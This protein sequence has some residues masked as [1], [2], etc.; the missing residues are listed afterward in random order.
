[1]LEFEDSRGTLMLFRADRSVQKQSPF[2]RVSQGY[3]GNRRDRVRFTLS[4][5]SLEDRVVMTT[6]P[7]TI[8]L[9]E[10]LPSASI[11]TNVTFTATV[12]STNG[13]P[14]GSVLFEDGSSVLGSGTLSG[15]VAAFSTNSLPIGVHQIQAFYGGTSTYLASATASASA[16]S[17]INTVAGNGTGCYSGDG[18]PATSAELQNPAYAAFDASG[19]MFISDSGN[20]VIRK[21]TPS[22]IISTYAGNGTSGYSGDGGAATSA[23]LHTP[24]GLAVDA[25]GDL[26]IADSQNN[27]IREVNT[28]GMIS[29][30][31]GNG[32]YGYTGDGGPATNAEMRYPQD[33]K[34]NTSGDVF[35]VD[36][37]NN[38]I[39]EVSTTGIISTVAGNGSAGYSGDGGP[40]TSAQLA[41]PQ[42][43]AFDPSGDMFIADYGNNV[44]R[45]VS[46]SGVISTFAGNGTYAYSGDGGPATSAAIASPEGIAFD[47]HG[48]LFIADY[49]NSVIR[50]VTPNGIISTFAGN[51]TYT[52]TGD[53]GPAGLAGID[54]PY[55]VA[56]SPSGNIAITDNGNEV[57][58]EVSA[59]SSVPF[60]FTVTAAPARVSLVVNST[61]QGTT[62]QTIV[63]T[64]SGSPING[65]TVS[66]Y[67]GTTLLG[68]V[69]VV[70]GVAVFN[71]SALAPGT[72]TLSAVFS[73]SEDAAASSASQVVSIAAATSVSP[74]LTGLSR[75]PLH[76]KRTLVS[77]FFDQTLNPAEALWKH[78]YKLHNSYGERINVSH[79]YF[80]QPSNT[81]T[82]LPAHRIVL[83]NMYT[84]KLVGLNSKS[85]GKGSSPTVSSTGWLADSFK[86]KINHK[87][88]SAPGAPPAITFVNGQE[89]A[90]RG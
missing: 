87:A 35:V 72:H 76:N 60:T 44:I 62:F 8:V 3:S 9:A 57:V 10:S 88:L 67:D 80:D 1:M 43:I 41:S 61:P 42:G 24:E 50:E 16:S 39:R 59:T 32:T 82:L 45:E 84:L 51:H 36:Y 46:L 19:N 73:G 85:G 79:I 55:D 65:G 6:Y 18:G 70:N 58:R 22:G 31:A 54:S 17:I 13:V 5:E 33:V 26:F 23:E 49:G 29:T 66:F 71:Y 75:Y 89:V 30:F 77:L 14:T 25:A 52:Y 12:S 37:D 20:N 40:A 64:A 27:R 90:R 48:D 63:D 7:T 68:V 28:S 69:P 4:L 83:R 38:V 81:V 74:S 53:G 34:V 21:V 86:A 56:V 78:N 15:G 47:T 2:N 11:G